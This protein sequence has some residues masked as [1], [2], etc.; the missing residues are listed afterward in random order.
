[1]CPIVK[2]QISLLLLLNLITTMDMECTLAKNTLKL[3]GKGLVE[4]IHELY[5]LNAVIINLTI[6]VIW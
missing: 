5:L 2:I 1:M 4:V 6:V 3:N